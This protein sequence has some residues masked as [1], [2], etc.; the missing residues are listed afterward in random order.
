M[1]MLRVLGADLRHWQRYDG[2]VM[3]QV[4]KRGYAKHRV[5][6]RH[7]RVSSKVVEGVDSLVGR[8]AVSEGCSIIRLKAGRDSLCSSPSV[9]AEWCAYR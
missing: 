3:D 1:P 7:G 2:E 9:G 5:K 4:C 6:E 8:M